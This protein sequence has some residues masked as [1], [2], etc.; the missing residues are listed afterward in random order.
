MLI[1]NSKL[2]TNITSLTTKESAVINKVYSGLSLSL[3]E[4]DGYI[5]LSHTD[6]DPYLAAQIVFTSQKLLQKYLTTFK[7]DKARSNLSFVEKSFLDSKKNFEGKQLELAKFRDSNKNLMSSLSKAEE[8]KLTSEYNLLYRLYTELALQYEQAKISVTE[9]TPVLTIIK[10]VVVPQTKS[11][12]KRT[13]FVIGLTS[14]GIILSTLW[15]LVKDLLIIQFRNIIDK[16]RL[17]C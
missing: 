14:I 5:T 12:P 10:P 13:I 16:A 1:S 9:E 8:E 3:N 2:T 7:L 15:I 6:L 11:G 4:K 17:S